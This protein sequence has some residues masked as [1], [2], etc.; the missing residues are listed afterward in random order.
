[1]WIKKKFIHLQCKQNQKK[2]KKT[3]LGLLL[4]AVAFN[5]SSQAQVKKDTVLIGDSLA[6][7]KLKEGNKFFT[8][9][10]GKKIR[11]AKSDKG[12]NAFIIYNTNA[13]GERRISKIYYAN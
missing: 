8:L 6:Y 2:M 4:V 3:V 12:K 9:Y 5:A 10:K 7:P 13:T 11:A 1:M